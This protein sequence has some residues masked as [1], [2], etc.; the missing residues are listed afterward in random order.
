MVLSCVSFLDCRQ[1]EDDQ[2]GPP[3]L[4][5]FYVALLPSHGGIALAASETEHVGLASAD[6][7]PWQDPI[8]PWPAGRVRR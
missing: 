5:V 3:L 8:F 7:D 1:I 4:R 2:A 6:I